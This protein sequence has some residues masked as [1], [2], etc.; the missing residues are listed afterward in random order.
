MRLCLR[1]RE[2]AD[3]RRHDGDAD[4]AV[5]LV[6]VGGADDDVRLLIGLRTNAARRLVH[7]VEG[8]V[9]A[10]GDGDEKAARTFHGHVVE[11][12]VGDRRLR[13]L[14]GAP[15]AARLARAH[16]RLAPAGHDGAHVGKIE[17]DETFL[18]HE[19]GDAGDAGAQHVVGHAEG[20]GEGRLLVGDAEQVLVR[21]NKERID[22][23]L[24]LLD[25]GLGRAETARALELE[26][27]GHDADGEDALLARGARD[28]RRGA[29]AGTA[30]HTGRDEHH[31]AA[32]QMSLDVGHGLL[33]RGRADLGFGTSAKAFG[34][35]R[36]HLDAALGA[37]AHQG[38]RVGVG[39]DE[40]D[41]LQ[42]ARDHVVDGVAAGAAHTEHGNA[43]LE[44]GQIWNSDID[45]H[46]GFQSLRLSL[47]AAPPPAF[48]ACPPAKAFVS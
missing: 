31:V 32:D 46:G 15:V 24:K 8:E 14:D 10:A 20:I 37:R 16:H 29:G 26:G 48:P 30:A 42:A 12:R 47:A 33:G 5:E 11:Q 27:L 13:R 28:H 25:A 9:A 45:C 7:L 18:H 40:F 44:F 43:R 6:V 23:L 39:D 3:A 19:I 34:H 1:G 21:N 2:H 41:A 38:L 4:H 35:V 17:I 22:V 36:A